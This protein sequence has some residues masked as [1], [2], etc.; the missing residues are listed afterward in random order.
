MFYQSQ[1]VTVNLVVLRIYIIAYRLRPG[2]EKKYAETSSKRIALADKKNIIA[3]IKKLEDLF[4]VFAPHS[5]K[6]KNSEPVR[7]NIV[8]KK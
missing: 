2:K 5:C 1:A 7:L 8:K 6:A 3:N 4:N